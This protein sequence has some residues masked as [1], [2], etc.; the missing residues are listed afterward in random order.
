MVLVYENLRYILSV[1][2][3]RKLFRIGNSVDFGKK[4]F[5][6]LANSDPAIRTLTFT[7]FGGKA[8]WLFL[9]HLIW[10]N[11]VRILD[12]DAS[13]LSK[14]SA[15]LWLLGCLSAFLLSLYRLLAAVE[16]LRRIS[17][18]KST[19]KRR[20]STLRMEM[21]RDLCDCFIPLTLLNKVGPGIGW[22]A[23]VVSSI[24]ALKMEWRKIVLG[25]V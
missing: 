7:S 4:A 17:G 21:L 23:G 2:L 8:G 3:S 1:S 15:R 9:D 14:W 13:S 24:V 6:G 16:E 12:V 11:K 19:C 10:A 25:Q 5:A 18:D 22:T 20:V